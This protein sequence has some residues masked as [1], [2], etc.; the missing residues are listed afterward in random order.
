MDEVDL[1]DPLNWYISD[2]MDEYIGRMDSGAAKKRCKQN[3]LL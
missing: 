3:N 1:N 2:S